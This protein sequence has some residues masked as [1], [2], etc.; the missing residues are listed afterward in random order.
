MQQLERVQFPEQHLPR[1]LPRFR[2]GSSAVIQPETGKH[3]FGILSA[4]EHR[5]QLP[6]S[7]RLRPDPET[8]EE[9][10]DF[11][12]EDHQKG[13]GA[14]AVEQTGQTRK[15][16]F[17]FLLFRPLLLPLLR[18]RVDP[19][20]GFPAVKKRAQQ[21]RHRLRSLLLRKM[22]A[23][24]DHNFAGVPQE[25]GKEPPRFPRN[26]RIRLPEQQ[27]CR[28]FKAGERLLQQLV[29]G[30]SGILSRGPDDRIQTSRMAQHRGIRIQSLRTDRP[31]SPIDI[32][33]K[34]AGKETGTGEF[35]DT[36]TP[37]QRK[38]CDLGNVIGHRLSRCSAGDQAHPVQTRQDVRTPAQQH[39]D[40]TAAS[41][42]DQS[43]SPQFQRS[44]QPFKQR[45]LIVRG[46]RMRRVSEGKAESGKIHPDKPELF[47][48]E[49]EQALPRPGERGK[50]VHEQDHRFSGASRIAPCEE[51]VALPE[52]VVF[53]VRIS[54]SS[55]R[56]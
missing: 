40:F 16:S 30:I 31:F 27:Q 41:V 50:A 11:Q 29:S 53:R 33:Q 54:A 8:A 51:L 32:L 26:D 38:R 45:R 15:R 25:F 6:P 22:S 49:T 23:P 5:R 36:S 34:N 35:K 4:Q 17:S 14:P 24:G 28:Q 12:A 1:L 56:H 43:D 10:K 9:L 48:Q 13:P 37:R 21:F 47:R 18:G 46:E 3:E 42:T 20:P 44:D 39:A 52:M 55:R 7:V 19:Q 2:N